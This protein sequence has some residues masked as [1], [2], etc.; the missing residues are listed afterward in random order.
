MTR[1]AIRSVAGTRDDP[2]HLDLSKPSLNRFTK[3]G[4][5]VGSLLPNHFN[6]R[7]VAWKFIPAPAYSGDIQIGF[8]QSAQRWWPAIVVSHLANGIHGVE[9]YANGTW[10]PAQMNGDMGQSYVI[11]GTT[12]GGIQFRI[13]VRDAADQL[14][15]NGRVYE[16]TLPDSCA[17]ACGVPYTKVTYRTSA[18]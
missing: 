9:Y 16:F 13:R 6:N 1:S 7:H 17:S 4:V 11:G 8:L 3:N 18:G 10:R 14:I 15:N 2:Y 12:S 5:P